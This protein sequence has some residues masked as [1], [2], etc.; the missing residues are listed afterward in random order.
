[1]TSE[2]GQEYFRK[3]YH[4]HRW[5]G[6]SVFEHDGSYPG[7]VD[8]TPR[9]PLQKGEED[10]QWAQWRIIRDFYQWCRGEG[11]YLNVPGEPD[12]GHRRILHRHRR[13]RPR[14]VHGG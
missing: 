5:T 2:W 10:S 4:F 11:I 6:F 8:V 9:W 13:A 3:L 12:P 7:D 1:L 14:L